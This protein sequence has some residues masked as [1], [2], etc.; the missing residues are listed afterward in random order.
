MNEYIQPSLYT[1][2]KTHNCAS[3][4]ILQS[5]H[6]DPSG[7]GKKACAEALGRPGLKLG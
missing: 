5:T 1:R 3:M 7:R 4:H 2:I 6:R